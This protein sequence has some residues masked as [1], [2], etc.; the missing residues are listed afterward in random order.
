MTQPK[1]KGR[2]YVQNALEEAGNIIGQAKDKND[3]TG[4]IQAL[5]ERKLL[6]SFKNGITVG[7]KKAGKAK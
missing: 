7:M 1:D 4:Q 5:L 2:G 6:E 3:A